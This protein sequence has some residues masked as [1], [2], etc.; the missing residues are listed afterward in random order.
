MDIEFNYSVNSKKYRNKFPFR[1]GDVVKV[2]DWGCSFS[3]YPSAYVYF[4]GKNETPYFCQDKRRIER[5]SAIPFKIIALA[6]HDRIAVVL[7]YSR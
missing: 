7:L 2:T 5:N 1:V 4:K 6:E 3:T